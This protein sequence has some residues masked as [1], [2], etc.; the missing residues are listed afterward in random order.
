MSY[1]GRFGLVGTAGELAN[2]WLECRCV[3]WQQGLGSSWSWVVPRV[4]PVAEVG[5]EKPQLWLSMVGDGDDAGGG[6]ARM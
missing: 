2:P 5:H 1:R 6:V 3:G 4:N